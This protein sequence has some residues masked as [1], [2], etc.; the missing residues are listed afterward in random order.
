MLVLYYDLQSTYLVFYAIDAYIPNI[1]NK[2]VINVFKLIKI[3]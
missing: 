1:C 2:I 3:Y